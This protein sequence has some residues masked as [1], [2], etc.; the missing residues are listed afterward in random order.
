MTKKKKNA[1][2]AAA[3][4]KNAKDNLL[5]DPVTGEKLSVKEFTLSGSLTSAN[6]SLMFYKDR[7]Q[8]LYERR[9]SP[10]SHT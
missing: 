3:K 6:K 4:N 7:S 10:E 9:I 2:D 5:T 8:T 1:D